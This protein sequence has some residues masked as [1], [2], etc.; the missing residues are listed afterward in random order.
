MWPECACRLIQSCQA[1]L[2][3]V[4]G[5]TFLFTKSCIRIFFYLYLDNEDE[6]GGD[7]D[8]DDDNDD[9][10]DDDDDDNNDNL[11][12]LLLIIHH[13]PPLVSSPFAFSSPTTPSPS[14]SA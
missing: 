14:P 13:V 9:N 2:P 12:F 1:L 6:D 4:F 7:D 3:K 8:G 5:K 10:D 11:I